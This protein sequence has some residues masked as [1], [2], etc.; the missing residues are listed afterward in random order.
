MFDIMDKKDLQYVVDKGII[1]H[2][3]FDAAGR[4]TRFYYTTI[5]KTIVKEIHTPAVYKRKRKISNGGVYYKNEFIYDTIST[6]FYYNEDGRLK[7]KRFNDG[8]YYEAVYYAYNEEGFAVKELKCKE[9]NVSNDK[10]YFQLGMQTILSDEEFQ[11]EKIGDRQFKKKCFNDEGR[12]F[13]EIII[14]ST[15]SNQTLSLNESFVATWIN[16]STKY[17]YNEKN[18]QVEKIFQTNS[19]GTL[20]L[21]ETTDYDDKGNILT[22]KQYK[23]EVLQN[24]LS[25]LFDPDA[26]VNSFLNRDHINK[27][28][29]ITKV[30]YDY[31]P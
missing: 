29:R 2:F 22:V 16:Q 10:S 24:E 4:L 3:D 7:L 13:K 28:I 30:Y 9:T 14:N 15:P 1:Q 6:R 31:Q 12:V 26:K 18:Q 27:S 19:S 23:N 17:K 25:Y 11:Y 21:K 20:I 5:V 8:I